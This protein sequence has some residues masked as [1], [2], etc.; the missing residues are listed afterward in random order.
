MRIAEI[1]PPWV[2]VPPPRNGGIEL[3]VSLIADGLVEIMFVA[4][5]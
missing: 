3:V 4:A 1:A 2:S 5:K